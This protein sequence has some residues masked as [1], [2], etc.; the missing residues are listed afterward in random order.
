MS[1]EFFI[2]NSENHGKQKLSVISLILLLTISG[3]VIALPTTKA[4]TATSPLPT[5][6]F[7]NVSPNPAGVGEQATI[8]MWLASQP[9]C[10]W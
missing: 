7:C 1:I 10:I 9:D 8:E 2:R 3:A 5:N 6:A 4:Q